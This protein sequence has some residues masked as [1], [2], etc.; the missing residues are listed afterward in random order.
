VTREQRLQRRRFLKVLGVTGGAAVSAACATI[1]AEPAAPSVPRPDTTSAEAQVSAASNI[2]QTSVQP[3]LVLNPTEYAFVEAA[4]D[5]LIPA[6]DLTPSGSACGV[7]V[8]IDRQLAGAFGSGARLYRSGPFL[9]GKPEHG[10]QLS[11]TPRELFTSV[12]AEINQ[13]TQREHAVAFDALD[14]SLRIQVLTQLEMGQSG[15]AA[16]QTFFELL[17]TLS[18]EG[19]FADPLYGGNRD[20]VS[21][22]MLGYPGLPATYHSDIAAYRGR[23]FERE[24]QSILD[25]S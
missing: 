10:Y 21:W 5:T 12:I 16:G 7:A 11:L 2:S 24:P 19:F 20:K 8:F 18:M 23:R 25:F 9:Q 14:E 1:P 3:A 15:V 22:R 6:D 13:W 17:L 4:V